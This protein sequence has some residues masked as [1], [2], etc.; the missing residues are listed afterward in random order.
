[1]THKSK[2]TYFQSKCRNWRW[3]I[4]SQRKRILEENKVLPLVFFKT[5][6]KYT[7]VLQKMVTSTV[8]NIC[9]LFILEYL[10]SSRFGYGTQ[11]LVSLGKLHLKHVQITYL[12]HQL[13]LTFAYFNVNRDQLGFFSFLFFFCICNSKMCDLM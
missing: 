9:G 7:T 11:S 4:T 8:K 13:F 6:W 10:V 3:V 5:W 1:M 12:L 2:P